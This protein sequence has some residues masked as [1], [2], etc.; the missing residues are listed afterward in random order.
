MISYHLLKVLI[1]TSISFF[2][3]LAA[4]PL[5]SKL[6]LRYKTGKHIRNDGSTP[7]FSALHASKNGTPNMAG[8]L[9]WAT[10]SI[11]ISFF[12]FFDRILHFESFHILN[13]LTRKETLLPLGAFIGASLV[14][15]LDDYLDMV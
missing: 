5:L 15:L 7:V 3:A 11:L 6:L 1:L 13:F 14:G 12:W 2:F 9:I 4:T 10:T 8:V